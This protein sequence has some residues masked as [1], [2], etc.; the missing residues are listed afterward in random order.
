MFTAEELYDVANYM[1]LRAGAPF[2]YTGEEN[3]AQIYIL[4]NVSKGE[5]F[6]KLRYLLQITNVNVELIIRVITDNSYPEKE[7][8]YVLAEAKNRTSKR[9]EENGQS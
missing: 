6:N 1:I 4:V 8:A 7:I 9:G 3:E 2:V 5:D